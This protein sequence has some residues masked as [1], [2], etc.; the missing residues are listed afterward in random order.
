[1]APRAFPLES[2]RPWM[3]ALQLINPQKHVDLPPI[4]SNDPAARSKEP[5]RRIAFSWIFTG[6]VDILNKKRFG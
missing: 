3:H 1:M 2:L 4:V 6:L 5:E